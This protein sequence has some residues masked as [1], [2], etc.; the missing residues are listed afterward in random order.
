ML[1]VTIFRGGTLFWDPS[2]A[3]NRSSRVNE[4]SDLA[5]SPIA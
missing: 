1:A 2:S 5:V 3:G 4:S